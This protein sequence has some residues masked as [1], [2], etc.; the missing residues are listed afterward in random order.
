MSNDYKVKLNIFEGPLDL[1]LHLIKSNEME[2]SEISISEITTQYMDY[3]RLMETLDLE[4]AG[5]FL[6]MAATLLNIKLRALLPS[7]EEEEELEE[8]VD[9]FMSARALMQQLVEYRKFKEAAGQLGM[10]AERRAQVFIREVALPKLSDAEND[11]QVQG[12]LNQLLEAFSRVLKFV[13]RRDYHQIEADEYLVA[14]KI[15]LIRRR[16]FTCD[17][18]SL[19]ELFKNCVAKV[20]MIVTVISILELCRLKELRIVQ[21]ENFSD[22][23]LYHKNINDE[24][25]EISSEAKELERLEEDIIANRTGLVDDSEPL[26]EEDEL[27]AEEEGEV[28]D[29]RPSFVDMAP[30]TAPDEDSEWDEPTAEPA[31]PAPEAEYA[32]PAEAHRHVSDFPLVVDIAGEMAAKVAPE[33]PV[34]PEADGEEPTETSEDIPEVAEDFE[35]FDARQAEFGNEPEE[36]PEEGLD[37]EEL[38]DE[39]PEDAPKPPQMK[40]RKRLPERMPERSMTPRSTTATR[41]AKRPRPKPG[42]QA[43]RRPLMTKKKRFDRS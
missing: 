21:A 38:P 11:P 14:D 15:D 17:Y 32:M 4:V 24:E 37:G 33:P 5:D 12:E 39:L 43:P 42:K 3:L 35:A 19:Q 10:N 7:P 6:V 25:S 41:A 23:H 34:D 31:E 27:L 29:E 16:L 9:E 40:P 36:L 13:S 20:E 28:A 30:A 1:L 8:D 22:L 18:L 2:I 26:S